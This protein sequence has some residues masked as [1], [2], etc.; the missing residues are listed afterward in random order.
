MR[1]EVSSWP[2]LRK[3]SAGFS[4]L[5]L[6]AIVFSPLNELRQK[7]AV[8]QDERN[9]IR[10]IFDFLHKLSRLLMSREAVFCDS[11]GTEPVPYFSSGFRSLLKFGDQEFCEVSVAPIRSSSGF[12]RGRFLECRDP[13][14]GSDEDLINENPFDLAPCG[15]GE[16]GFWYRVE[17]G[18]QVIVTDVMNAPN[19]G[20]V[21]GNRRDLGW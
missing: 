7:L 8:I 18:A 17:Q 11:K 14:N 13:H 6:F 20:C 9:Q 21:L 5:T 2:G 4:K 15:R 19:L 3:K 12:D 1:S 16:I 10:W